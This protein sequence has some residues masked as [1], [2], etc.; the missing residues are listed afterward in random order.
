MLPP[1]DLG[2]FEVCKNILQEGY[3]P[4][5]WVGGPITTPGVHTT[6]TQNALGCIYQQIVEI[7]ELPIEVQIIDTVG[8]TNEDMVIEGQYFTYEC[9]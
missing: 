8:C 5:D 6:D 9:D 1:E 3:E 7:I 2:S 4:P